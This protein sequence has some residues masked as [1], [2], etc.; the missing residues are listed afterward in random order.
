MKSF[1]AR[2]N[3]VS[4]LFFISTFL[5]LIISIIAIVYMNRTVEMV[6]TATQNHLRAAAL[7]AS[8]LLSVEELDQ[9]HTVE[10]MK[11]PEWESLRARLIEFGEKYQVLYVYYWRDYGDGR[12]QYIIDND[13]DP[14]N[15]ANPDMFFDFD[16]PVESI[17]AGE[18]YTS[19]LGVYTPTWDDLISGLAPVFAKDGSVYCAAGVD[20]SD[21]III[22][23]RRNMTILRSVLIGALTLSLLAN[24]VGMW[25]YRKKALQSESANKSKS[26]FLSTMSHEIRTPMN[27]VIGISELALREDTS[28]KVREYI[29]RIKQA[30]VSLLAIIN[31]ILD[32]SKIEAG[33]MEIHPARYDLSSLLNDVATIIGIRLHDKSLQFKVNVDKSLPAT[34]YGDEIRIRQILLNLLSNAVKYTKEGSIQFSVSGEALDAGNITLKFEISDTGIGIKE[35]DLKNIFG[36]FARFDSV[37]NRDVEG[38]GLGLAITSTLCRL[39]S[40]A[41]SVTSVYGKGS[42]FTACLPQK[43]ID[44]EPVSAH[45]SAYESYPPPQPDSTARFTAPDARLLIVDDISSNLLVARGLLA[46]YKMIIDCCAGG[47]EAVSLAEKNYYDLI[48]M[49]HL[50]PGMDGVETTA[51]IRAAKTPSSGA[52]IIALTANVLSGMKEMFLENGFD[53]YLTKPIEIP[54]LDALV[55][56]WIPKE[57]MKTAQEAEREAR[58]DT[59]AAATATGSGIEIPGVDTVKGIAMTGGTVETYRQVLSA[60]CSD[61]EERFTWLEAVP[62]ETQLPVF[63]IH[64]HALKSASATIGAEILSGEAAALEAA[65]KAGDLAV[66]REKLPG[67]YERL[68]ETAGNVRAALGG[69]KHPPESGNTVLPSA[70]LREF[71]ELRN[72]LERQDIETIDRVLAEMNKKPFDERTLQT[73]ANISDQILMSEFKEAAQTLKV[74]LAAGS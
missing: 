71:T 16:D 62:A 41:V 49:D 14:E 15:M 10:D 7:A 29:G 28:P 34:L 47:A 45:I 24:G 8:T 20:I 12:I 11:K 74:L 48:F 65:G 27:A 3:R 73:L 22:I 69:G 39:M 55:K 50:M 9:F 58:R 40:G 33:K 35:E 46:P 61:A 66:I 31:D 43:V 2:L 67:F 23:Q 36:N 72:A 52:P 57:K 59:P 6:E 30:G 64:A 1:G 25:F 63:T 4:P 51:K 26:Q 5:V 68:V 13:P 70:Y 56:K 18:I 53:D 38:T 54:K 32:F 60:F 21:E 37:K 17:L 44:A 19:D 42:V